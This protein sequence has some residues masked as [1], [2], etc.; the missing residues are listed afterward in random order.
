MS[1]PE[2]KRIA[3]IDIYYGVEVADPYRWLEDLDGDETKSW[4]EA[5]NALSFIWPYSNDVETWNA[6]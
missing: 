3:Q 6:K 4:I 2:T 1:Y 5:Q